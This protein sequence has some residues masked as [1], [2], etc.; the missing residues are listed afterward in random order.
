[1]QEEP[2]ESD[3]ASLDF[4]IPLTIITV[5]VGGVEYRAIDLYELPFAKVAGTITVH[6]PK[7]LFEIIKLFKL[8]LID[9]K[10][11]E[12]INELPFNEV[13]RLAG[14]WASESSVKYFQIGTEDESD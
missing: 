13:T 4:E 2:N 14:T 1:M 3:I 7:Q 9:P 11:A 8:A 10:Q 5:E 12:K 6:G